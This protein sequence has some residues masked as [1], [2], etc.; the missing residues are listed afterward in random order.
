VYSLGVL[1][2]FASAQAAVVRL[3]FTDPELERPYLVPVNLRIRGRPVPVAALVGIPL[4]AALWIAALVTHQAA[5]IGGPAWLLPGA[6]LYVG[7]AAS[8]AAGL[9]GHAR[10]PPPDP[11]PAAEGASGPIPG[12]LKIGP[13]AEERL[14]P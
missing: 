6:V 10:P 14:A 7:A 9:L 3:R 13:T 2:T 1:I 8:P 4:T 5:R 11:W 12:P